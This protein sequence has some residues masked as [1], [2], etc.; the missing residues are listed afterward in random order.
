MDWI[1]GERFVG[2][3]KYIYTP[4]T[5]RIDDYNGI[6]NTLNLDLLQDGDI[7][8]THGLYLKIFFRVMATTH[9]HYTL[10]SHNSDV[11]IDSSFKWN[12]NLDHWFTQNVNINMPHFIESIPIGL[13]N[14]RWFRHIK[15]K[16]KMEI[17]LA[18]PNIYKNLVYMNFNIKTNRDER[19]SAYKALKNK[20]WV[21]E[22]MKVNGYDFDNYIYNLKNHWF[23]ACPE[24][25]GIDT[26]RT[27]ET[28]YMGSIPIEKRNINNQFYKDLP[29][30]FVDSWSEITEKFLESEYERIRNTFWN[31]E[32]LDFS[33]WANKIQSWK[34]GQ[35]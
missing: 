18:Q 6:P 30:C 16:E 33:Y 28:L 35:Q 29:I 15:K 19:T 2:L 31:M 5:R 23:V 13:E 24:G 3:A 4:K 27:W 20:S 34:N 11:N 1:Q 25:N 7:I 8:Y 26:H 12:N 32:K 17:V 10:I 9:K 22:D 21:T 14:N